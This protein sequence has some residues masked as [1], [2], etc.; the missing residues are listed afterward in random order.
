MS[1]PLFVRCGAISR[2]DTLFSGL[3]K[4]RHP[5]L[6][7]ASVS[8]HLNPQAT[9]TFKELLQRSLNSRGKLT[10]FRCAEDVIGRNCLVTYHQCNKDIPE[11]SF[12]EEKREVLA[13]GGCFLVTNFLSE[14]FKNKLV[15]CVDRL[16]FLESSQKIGRNKAAKQRFYRTATGAGRGGF[17]KL[18]SEKKALAC[19]DMSAAEAALTSYVSHVMEVQDACV[20]RENPGKITCKWVHQS[21]MVQ[22]TAGSMQ[23]SAYGRHTD[24]GFHHNHG[25][26]D[27]DQVENDE[28]F[29]V[30]SSLPSAKTMRVATVVVSTVGGTNASLMF[31]DGESEQELFT[32]N[33][34]ENCLHV[35]NFGTQR[36]MQHEVTSAL[37]VTG[38]V[39]VG[40]E[41][42]NGVRLV[43]SFRYSLDGTDEEMLPRMAAGDDARDYPT[44][45]DYN[46]CGVVSAIKNGES[47]KE[48][49]NQDSNQ[50]SLSSRNSSSRTL[51]DLL[52]G[53]GDVTDPTALLLAKIPGQ[54]RQPSVSA[55]DSMALDTAQMLQDLLH[56]GLQARFAD[57]KSLGARLSCAPFLRVLKKN[58]I[59][60][61][62]R[63]RTKKKVA[64]IKEKVDV[65]HSAVYGR[66]PRAEVISNYPCPEVL[67]VR[68]LKIGDVLKEGTV[69]NLFGIEYNDNSS[70]PWRCVHHLLTNCVIIAQD[71]KNDYPGIRKVQQQIAE[72]KFHPKPGE[73]MF[74]VGGSGGS[75]AQ[76]GAVAR[77][78]ARE[79][80]TEKCALFSVADDQNGLSRMN[81][82]FEDTMR[83]GGTVFVFAHPIDNES[84]TGRDERH[85][86]YL[87]QYTNSRGRWGGIKPEEF[88]PLSPE[89]FARE[90]ARNLP[91]N[92][93][94]IKLHKDWVDRMSE[95]DELLEEGIISEEYI[96]EMREHYPEPPQPSLE[97]LTLWI[98]Q[99]GAYRAHLEFAF[100][101]DI[102]DEAR[103]NLS[104]EEIA[105]SDEQLRKSEE[106]C[107][108]ANIGHDVGVPDE[109]GWREAQIRLGGDVANVKATVPIPE[110]KPTVF[111]QLLC[112]SD[113]SYLSN[114]FLRDRAG[115]LF[116]DEDGSGD[117][118]HPAL[119]TFNVTLKNMFNFLSKVSVGA[120]YRAG[121]RNV[122]ER[123]KRKKGRPVASYLRRNKYTKRLGHLVRRSP[124]PFP[125]RSYDMATQFIRESIAAD[126]PLSFGFVEN[127]DTCM[128]RPLQWFDQD[129]DRMGVLKKIILTS[130]IVRSTGRLEKLRDYLEYTKAETQSD[131]KRCMDTKDTDLLPLFIAATSTS[132]GEGSPMHQK[133]LGGWINDQFDETLPKAAKST[134]RTLSSFLRSVSN[135]LDEF[136]EQAVKPGEVGRPSREEVVTRLAKIMYAG[137]ISREEKMSCCMFLAHQVIADLEEFAVDSM[138]TK[139]SPFTGNFVF[140]GYGCGQGFSTLDHRQV[141]VGS[142]IFSAALEQ[143]GQSEQKIYKMLR[144]AN[145]KLD[146]KTRKFILDACVRIKDYI[147]GRDENGNWNVSEGELS[148][149]GLFRVEEGGNVAPG[150]DQPEMRP[151]GVYVGINGRRISCNDTEHMLCK[152]YL[153]GTR[154]RGSR[155]H[156]TS[157]PWRNYCWPTVRP[158][159]VGCT[160]FQSF[161]ELNIID[162]YERMVSGDW[163]GESVDEVLDP[164]KI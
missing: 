125:L 152:V 30:W 61:D 109:E 70:P 103:Q 128:V 141:L 132:V 104:L 47:P 129:K 100:L 69:R 91:S 21:T 162:S 25:F 89:E 40:R 118:K 159:T 142:A 38:A 130:L 74:W 82:C 14:K 68:R 39:E 146:N 83:K 24:C 7:F 88:L 97:H 55:S 144:N 101:D 138:A 10:G 122:V 121:R 37:G 27:F 158:S 116:F 136:I 71:Y 29:E 50:K 156:N 11:N 65:L 17:F 49:S 98:A 151:A 4:K 12:T 90:Y 51:S 46:I 54:H 113:P 99:N 106:E 87:G 96:A 108:D 48:Y 64:G 93:R 44:I 140:A 80:Q 163:A 73:S 58:K 85:L 157:K 135:K 123:K 75:P 26:Q 3:G 117:E 131:W 66:P 6:K 63:W 18:S 42:K 143:S 111:E 120:A 133:C 78:L 79:S 155:S 119:E 137:S 84:P 94:N 124:S 76:N 77:P 150:E 35:Q 127:G 92:G 154:T 5:G 20:A 114:E 164:F 16:P 36:Y 31:R 67:V 34:T 72:G 102:P 126:Y 2:V 86:Q 153:A 62:L 134:P 1:T 145:K 95:L 147:E 161:L 9:T 115:L 13:K 33:T 45:S 59:S 41:K 60:I 81:S 28:D 19:V 8:E 139:E 53:V 149:L 22:I 43:F 160:Q 105:E 52:G 15:S 112:A 57:N 110:D 148:M 32:V 23:D 56:E 107:P